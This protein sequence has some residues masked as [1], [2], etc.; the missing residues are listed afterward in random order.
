MQEGHR[1]H[2]AVAALQK[3]FHLLAQQPGLLAVHLKPWGGDRLRLERQ[4]KGKAFLQR[5][6]RVQNRLKRP[7][8]TGQLRHDAIGSLVFLAHSVQPIGARRSGGPAR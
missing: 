5:V 1:T 8:P 4:P 6:G 2:A 3:L 7:C